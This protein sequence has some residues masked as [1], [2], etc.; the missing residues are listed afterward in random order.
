MGTS[1]CYAFYN[2][3][4]IVISFH[5]QASVFATSLWLHFGSQDLPVRYLCML[6]CGCSNKRRIT[7]K[8]KHIH[9]ALS[10]AL[11]AVCSTEYIYIFDNFTFLC[12]CCQFG[13]TKYYEVVN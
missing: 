6:N 3:G 4:S 13:C 7:G 9:F 2:K 10:R 8:V 5:S 1:L 12:L 11:F